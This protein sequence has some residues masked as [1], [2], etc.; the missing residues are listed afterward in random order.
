MQVLFMLHLFR[1]VSPSPV[2]TLHMDAA[3][4]GGGAAAGGALGKEDARLREVVLAEIL[5]TRPSTRWDDVAGLAAAKQ[6]TRGALAGP[7]RAGRG[8][9]AAIWPKDLV[10][11]LTHP[12]V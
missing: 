11:V 8:R 7:L 12:C 5:D 10:L 1:N 3:R 6:V 9:G 4:P 2:R